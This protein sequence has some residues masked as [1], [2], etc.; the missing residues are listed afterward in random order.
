MIAHRNDGFSPLTREN[1]TVG[2]VLGVAVS[3]LLTAIPV[4]AAHAAT[5]ADRALA[6]P[7]A[8]TR[9]STAPGHGKSADF[10]DT[11]TFDNQG[12]YTLTISTGAKTCIRSVDPE[13]VV[14]QPHSKQ[15]VK[16]TESNLDDRTT[17]CGGFSKS[18]VWNA[19][20]AWGGSQP[21]Q[22]AFQLTDHVWY[23]IGSLMIGSPASYL[24][25][26]PEAA[27]CTMSADPNGK[28]RNCFNQAVAQFG[29]TTITISFP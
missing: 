3:L 28:P 7:S 18:L 5:A 15:V 21:G 27:T 26:T 22:Y 23:G 11:V 12:A 24:P 8:Q 29:L 13:K 14:V 20:V 2:A 17:Q 19:S 4:G 6:T 10:V 9:Q 16:V 1:R 25:G